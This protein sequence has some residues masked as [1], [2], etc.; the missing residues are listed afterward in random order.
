MRLPAGAASFS[1][2][3]GLAL[4]LAVVGGYGVMANSV[5]RRTRKIG[6]RMA[7]GAQHETVQWK[8]PR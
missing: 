3:G 4:A 1:A 5:A 8:I 7:L 2:F 6:T